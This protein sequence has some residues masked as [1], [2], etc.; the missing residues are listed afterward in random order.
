[1]NSRVAFMTK[2]RRII[3][4]GIEISILNQME[5]DFISLTD[6]IKGFGDDTMLYSWMRS[7]NTLSSF[8]AFGNRFIIHY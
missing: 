7:R 3:V 5:Q 6:M 2:R 1:M 8:W 4:K